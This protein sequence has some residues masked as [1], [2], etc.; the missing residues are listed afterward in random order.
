MTVANHGYLPTYVLS[1]AR[2]LPWNEPLFADVE[3][4]GCALAQPQEA[5]REVGH[6]D[7][8]GRGRFDGESALFYQRSRG[9]TG[10]KTLTW[11]VRGKGTLTVR[12][13][14]C[15]TGTVTCTATV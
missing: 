14:S 8:W 10:R 5:H 9:S 11:V 1:S 3:A 2:K 6:L 4:V 13:G 12:V 7:G 15:R